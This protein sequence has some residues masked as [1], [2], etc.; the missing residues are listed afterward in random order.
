MI[1]LFCFFPNVRYLGCG[2]V[3]L[4]MYYASEWDDG[5]LCLSTKAQLA[6]IYFLFFTFWNWLDLEIQIVFA[7]VSVFFLL[8]FLGEVKPCARILE[9]PYR[10][11][12]HFLSR[13]QLAL[14]MTHRWTRM[15]DCC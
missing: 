1:C 3:Y 4:L 10:H 12:S 15:K 2:N 6:F 14:M 9:L 8:E 5:K 7:I 13:T 11:G